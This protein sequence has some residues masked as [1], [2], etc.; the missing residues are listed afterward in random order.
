MPGS[1][2][3]SGILGYST[4]TYD[5]ILSSY[6]FDWLWIGDL[7][8]TST[9][10]AEGKWQLQ[11]MASD[12]ADNKS[13]TQTSETLVVDTTAPILLSQT[14]FEDKWYGSIQTVTFEYSDANMISTYEAPSCEITTES[15]ASYCWVKPYICDT[16]GNCNNE[17]VFSTKI[18]MDMTKPS[19]SLDVW[20]SELKGTASDTLSGIAKVVI[21]LTKPGATEETL[22][23]SGTTSWNYVIDKAL[24]GSYKVKVMAY[25][26]ADNIS[27]TIERTYDINASDPA[28]TSS[29]TPTPTPTP[30]PT[31]M[32][33][34][35]SIS[36]FTPLPSPS[37]ILSPTPSGA[38]LGEETIPK[39]INYWWLLTMAPISFVVY[40]LAIKK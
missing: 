3:G 31:A 11:V 33:D 34:L 28:Q 32:P 21:Q 16:A 14:G 29:A 24:V 38:V 6:P 9:S 7:L 36:T 8:T 22:T 18:K 27:S 5:V 35:V 2:S 30:S 20:G 26:N 10:L 13:E 17:Q 19:V 25:D 12:K 39:K 15:S 40:L 23:A 37:P 1:D 4:R